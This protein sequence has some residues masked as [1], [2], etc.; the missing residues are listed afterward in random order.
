VMRAPDTRAEIVESLSES[1]S[2]PNLRKLPRS[3][4][5]T[6]EDQNIRN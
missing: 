4:S 2:S 5:S 3:L 6:S 1:V